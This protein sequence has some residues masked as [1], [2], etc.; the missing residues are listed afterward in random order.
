MG[1]FGSSESISYEREQTEMQA[2]LA[3]M[4]GSCSGGGRRRH[5]LSG[6]L[7]SSLPLRAASIIV[8]GVAAPSKKYWGKYCLERMGRD[9]EDVSGVALWWVAAESGRQSKV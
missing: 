8:S 1:I 3:T 9:N 7:R 5:N 6:I 4:T 2:L